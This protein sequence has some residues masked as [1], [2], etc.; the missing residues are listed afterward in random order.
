MFRREAQHF[1]VRHR[2]AVSS[3]ACGEK[4]GMRGRF[5]E[6]EPVE[7]PPTRPSL[8][9]AQ[10]RWP[11]PRTRGE[12][13][14]GGLR[15]R[16]HFF[17]PMIPI[18]CASSTSSLA[19]CRP[20]AS[21][22]RNA[23]RAPRRRQASL[24]SGLSTVL[25]IA[26]SKRL[27]HGFGRALR[28]GD[29]A[30]GFERDVEAEL[31]GGR[32]VGKRRIAVRR[33]GGQQPHLPALDVLGQRRRQLHHRVHLAA[34]QAGDDLRGAERHVHHVGRRRRGTAPPRRCGCGC[35]RRNC[36]P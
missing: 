20:N 12:E 11:S 25:L 31:A 5:R 17:S 24:N 29:A 21:A 8:V 27:D 15:R 18:S 13:R 10:T 7:T 1:L 32:H 6:P 14:R 19:I 16:H 4:V 2:S 26:A 36:R 33:D 22:G 3:P 28:G 23:G 35:R 30:P 9:L 34:E